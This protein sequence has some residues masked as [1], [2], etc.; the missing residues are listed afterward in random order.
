MLEEEF[1]YNGSIMCNYLALLTYCDNHTLDK[2]VSFTILCIYISHWLQY[3]P[4]TYLLYKKLYKIKHNLLSFPKMTK[5]CGI[6]YWLSGL[7]Q[8]GFL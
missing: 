8:R 6:L 2:P 7:K 5:I 1:L 3:S 4:L